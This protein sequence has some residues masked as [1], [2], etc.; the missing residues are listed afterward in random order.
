[1][2]AYK[3]IGSYYE[4][5]IPPEK[6]PKTYKIKAKTEP[7]RLLTVLRSKTYL[8]YVPTRNTVIKTPF[9]K[10]YK[11]KNPLTLKGVS[12]PIEI[13]PLNNVAV[14]KDSIGEEVSLDLPEIDDIDFSKLITPEVPRFSKPPELLA[15]GP[16]KPLEPE[17]R[18]LEPM[19]RPFE[20]PIKSV[21]S[22]DLDEM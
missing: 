6:R 3:A 1:M 5:F 15:P 10:L 21:D 20:E 14:T 4:V 8:V 17:N 12:K 2:K 16:S 11:P 19:L 13:R 7:R 22:L 9:I 18:P